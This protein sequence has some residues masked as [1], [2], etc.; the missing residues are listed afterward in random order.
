VNTHR[1]YSETNHVKVTIYG[2]GARQCSSR[3][4]KNV[5]LPSDSVNNTG[6]FGTKIMWTQSF[7]PAVNVVLWC[8]CTNYPVHTH[9][10]T[11]YTN[12][13]TV[14]LQQNLQQYGASSIK[15]RLCCITGSYFQ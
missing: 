3:R 2:L 8:I 13:A 1:N 14:F 7:T 6:H 5:L 10:S 11:V 12:G 4:C 15:N 9:W